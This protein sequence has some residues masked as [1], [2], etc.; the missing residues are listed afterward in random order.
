VRFGQVLKCKR[1]VHIVNGTVQEPL[2]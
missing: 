1:Q 2:G